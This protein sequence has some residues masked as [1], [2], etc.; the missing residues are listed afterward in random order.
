MATGKD[1]EADGKLDK[2]KG[3]I[4][5]GFGALTGD[6]STEAEGKMDRAKGG[7]QEKY[8]QVKSDITDSNR[9]IDRDP[10]RDP[11]KI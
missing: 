9:D 11:N 6:R 2:M 4:K 10:T 8:G 3:A 7:L 5:E 1:H